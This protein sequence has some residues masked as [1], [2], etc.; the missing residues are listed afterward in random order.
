MEESL[1]IKD[2]CA[3]LTQLCAICKKNE[4][5]KDH[6]KIC[7]LKKLAFKLAKK[8]LKERDGKLIDGSI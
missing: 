2:Y 5:C 3:Q 8:R 1:N 7:M 4:K 6:T